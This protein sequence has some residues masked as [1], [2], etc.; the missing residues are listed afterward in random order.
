MM[1]EESD[2]WHYP[3]TLIANCEEMLADAFCD[4]PSVACDDKHHVHFE[5]DGKSITCIAEHERA[6]AANGA[7]ITQ[8]PSK[9]HVGSSRSGGSGEAFWRTRLLDRRSYS[10]KEKLECLQDISLL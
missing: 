1:A 8:K 3:S 10:R 5:H 6:R 2:E 7:V 4:T 9:I